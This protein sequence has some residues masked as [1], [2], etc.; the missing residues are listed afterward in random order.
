MRLKTE[1]AS[2]KKIGMPPNSEILLEDGPVRDVV[3][4]RGLVKR[5]SLAHHLSSGCFRAFGGFKAYG[6][7]R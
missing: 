3:E 4:L 6:T 1:C 2:H 5:H 7:G